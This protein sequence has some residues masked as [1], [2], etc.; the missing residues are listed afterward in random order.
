MEQ[1]R[2]W[3]LLDTMSGK[4]NPKLKLCRYL[5]YPTMEALSSTFPTLFLTSLSTLDKSF[6]DVSSLEASKLFNIKFHL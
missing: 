3:K 6:G 5:S 1:L 2:I 4:Q